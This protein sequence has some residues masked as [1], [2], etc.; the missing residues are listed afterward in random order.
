MI[1]DGE[2]SLPKWGNKTPNCIF[3]IV[4]V[5]SLFCRIESACNRPSPRSE[6][7]LSF[8]PKREILLR[9]HTF[10]RYRSLNL[11]RDIASLGSDSGALRWISARGASYEI[12][13]A[14]SAFFAVKFPSLRPAAYS[15]NRQRC[16]NPRPRERKSRGRARP[17][18]RSCRL[19]AAPR[20]E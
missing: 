1:R 19:G 20:A 14:I 7:E 4:F 18:P 5:L 3:A 11:S 6:P 8:R 9:S 2:A 13:F 16:G 12:N 17:Y 15:P 10:A